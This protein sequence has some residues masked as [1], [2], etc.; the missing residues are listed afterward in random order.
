MIRD[1]IVKRR[2]DVPPEVAW[3]LLTDTIQR[4]RWGPSVREVTCSDRFI[5]KGSDG[6]VRTAIGLTLR[7]RNLRRRIRDADSLAALRDCLQTG[8]QADGRD[9]RRLNRRLGRL[10]PVVPDRNALARQTAK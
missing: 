1:F 2:F 5:R 9:P 10:P 4:P 7:G 8:P 3:N 6:L